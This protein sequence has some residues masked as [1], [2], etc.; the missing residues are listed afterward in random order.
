MTRHT[1]EPAEMAEARLLTVGADCDRL[2]GEAARGAVASLRLL[3]AAASVL[4]M[5]QAAFD[6]YENATAGRT[7]GRVDVRD[8]LAM[9]VRGRLQY[10]LSPYIEPIEDEDAA[11]AEAELWSLGE[12]PAPKE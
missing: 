1:D 12:D 3:E 7:T 2:L 11:E 10:L 5:R 6:Y 8:A 4:V 9:A